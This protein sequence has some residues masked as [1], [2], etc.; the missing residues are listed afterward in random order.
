MRMSHICYLCK[1]AFTQK[2][3]LL[4]HLKDRCKSPLLNDPVLLNEFLKEKELQLQKAIS[5]NGNHNSINSINSN[6]IINVNINVQPITKLS[7]DHISTDKMKSVIEKF[8]TDK[9]K[10]TLLLTEYINGLLCDQ[11]HPENHAVK[12]VKKYP[13]T[14]NSLTEDSEGNLVNI[15]KNLKDTCELLT[16]PVL[17]VLKKKMSEFLKK[18]R[19]DTEPDFDYGLYED[20]IRELRKEFKKE[21]IKKVLSSFLKNDLLNNIEMKLDKV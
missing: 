3:A 16:D 8:D 13:P 14:F 18:Y 10:L 9:S 15:I 2:H 11:D 17:E 5:I 20:G 19:A 6:N 12:Y 7:I 4:T 1:N 21:T